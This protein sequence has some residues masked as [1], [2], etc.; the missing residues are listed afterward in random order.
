MMKAII[1][2]LTLATAAIHLSFFT[3][4]PSNELIYGLNALGY[5]T[6]LAMLYLP[7]PLLDQLHRTA[8]RL[9]MGYA[10]L[11]IVAY[12]IFGVVNHEWTVPLGP[13]DKVIEVILIGLLWQEDQR[14]NMGPQ[15]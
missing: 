8:R 2:L 12:L 11:T 6:L 13:I 7:I 15:Q 14:S 4:D 1:I 3:P 10:A 5:V 9:L